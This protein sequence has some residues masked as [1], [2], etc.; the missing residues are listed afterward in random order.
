MSQETASYWQSPLRGRNC[1]KTA[2]LFCRKRLNRAQGLKLSAMRSEAS[3]GDP[4]ECAATEALS[5]A[6]LPGMLSEFSGSPPSIRITEPATP[7]P[8]P[9]EYPLHHP[10]ID[11]SPREGKNS[12]QNR[13][14]LGLKAPEQGKRPGRFFRG[15]LISGGR[16]H[17]W[18]CS[19][20]PASE[21][22]A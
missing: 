11:Q 21:G 22:P 13:P 20:L 19:A 18:G 8:V 1:P 17:S 12:P 16:K 7:I 15:L 3:A 14:Q 2:P 5:S 9:S 10:D 6:G 4:D